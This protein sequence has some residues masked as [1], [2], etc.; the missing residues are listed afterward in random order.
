M[1]AAS[2]VKACRWE[3]MPRI[4]QLEPASLA[5]KKAGSEVG[6]ADGDNMVNPRDNGEIG[7]LQ[8]VK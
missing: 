1:K 4:L 8:D 5:R 3:R 6:E 7:R 2:M